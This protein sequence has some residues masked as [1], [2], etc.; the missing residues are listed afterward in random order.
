MGGPTAS[1]PALNQFINIIPILSA[2]IFDVFVS[3]IHK[4]DR[5]KPSSS[6]AL[7]IIGRIFDVD[8]RANLVLLLHK[9]QVMIWNSIMV[10]PFDRLLNSQSMKIV[11]E[12]PMRDYTN[13]ILFVRKP[14]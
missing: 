6:Q 10:E 4:T 11:D 13:V 8:V 1:L 3:A 5:V 7:N 2:R 9:A 12:E 14:S